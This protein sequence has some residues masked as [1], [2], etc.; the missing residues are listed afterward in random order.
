MTT[1]AVS[2][3]LPEFWKTQASVWFAQ[4]EAQFAL[5]DITA[6]ATKYYYVVVALGSSTAGRVASILEIPPERGKY[7]RL[8]DRLLKI[9]GLSD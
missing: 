6:D 7:A 5:K 8:K 2:L 1:H 3:K 9:F 4:T